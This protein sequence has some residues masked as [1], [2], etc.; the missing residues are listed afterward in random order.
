MTTQPPHDPDACPNFDDALQKREVN[1]VI[2]A[3]L[4]AF[5][6]AVAATGISPTDAM[7][8]G[9]V[10]AAAFADGIY[11]RAMADDDKRDDP[12]TLANYQKTY[13]GLVE[14]YMDSMMDP[15]DD[16]EGDEDVIDP[17]YGSGTPT[18]Q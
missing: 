16:E 10:I 2:K 11:S 1:N 15:T 9:A 4:K 8:T 12:E 14:A 5:Y 7:V 13:I 6:D 18:V 17:H 3:T